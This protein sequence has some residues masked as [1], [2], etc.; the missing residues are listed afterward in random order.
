MVR[1]TCHTIVLGYCLEA[2]PMLIQVSVGRLHI[3]FVLKKVQSS[4]HVAYCHR[5]SAIVFIFR[6]KGMGSFFF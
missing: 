1:G 5:C 6:F 3:Y 2:V 4:G